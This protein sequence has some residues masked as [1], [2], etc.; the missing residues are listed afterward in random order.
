MLIRIHK[1]GTYSTLVGVAHSGPAGLLVHIA[2]IPEELHASGNSYI[3][4]CFCGDKLIKNIPRISPKFSEW[5]C[6][7]CPGT[8]SYMD[9]MK[10]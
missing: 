8:W 10:I 7:R 1:Y 6:L 3:S 9:C 4:Y 2:Y 5:M